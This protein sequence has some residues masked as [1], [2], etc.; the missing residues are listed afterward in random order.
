[1][2]ILFLTQLL[3]YPL[4]AGAKVRAYYVLRHLA[5][6]HRIT[7]VAFVRPTDSPQAIA[8]LQAFCHVHP[9]LLPR[10]T[11]R[12]GFHLLRSLFSMQ[13]FLI[14]RDWNATM[15]Q[16]LRTVIE[17]AV[18]ANEP[19]AAIHADQLWMA[20][21][22]LLARKL[23][24]EHKAMTILDQHNALFLIP[25]RLAEQAPVTKRLLLQWEARKLARYEVEIAGRFDK[26][27]WVTQ[28]D[29]QAVQVA[30]QCRG[31]TA[32]CTAVIPICSD[33][34]EHAPVVRTP[35]AQR[36]TFVG[37]LHYPPNAQ[38]ICWFAKAV[39]PKILRAAPQAILTVIGKAPPP[40]LHRLGI[41]T[42]NLE[43]VG[44]VENLDPY[45]SETAAFVAP[46]LSGGGMRVKIIDGWRWGMPVIST[47]IG[48]EGILCCPGQNILLAD[49]ATA[50]ADGTLQLLQ[51]PA[52]ADRLATAGRQW[53][54]QHYEW[55]KVYQSWDT[56][57]L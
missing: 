21:Y 48:A 51:Q 25:E 30:A 16:T 12:D 49:T 44:F 31:A 19:F 42:Q 18:R 43:V 24:S 28:A 13:P 55:R 29:Y 6:Q 45:L 4:D 27:V 2:N 37:G 22:A 7:L 47:T 46:L 36:V 3:P 57:Y 34:S 41:P 8:H 53:F 40:E 1:M 26:V 54:E 5:K 9:V 35:N 33:S 32:P 15:V 10:S 11:L 14:A 23:Q 52:V 56:I 38:G 50:L 39:F 20:P 17:A